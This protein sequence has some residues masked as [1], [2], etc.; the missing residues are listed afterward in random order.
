MTPFDPLDMR[1]YRMEQLP[2]R[3][4]GKFASRVAAAGPFLAVAAFLLFA[5]GFEIPFFRTSMRRRFPPPPPK[6]RMPSWV[7]RRSRAATK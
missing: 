5:F 3:E 4:K 2:K 7:R 6:R 1:N